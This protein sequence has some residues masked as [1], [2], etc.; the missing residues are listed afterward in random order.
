[1][2]TMAIPFSPLFD[3]PTS[4]ALPKVISH[5]PQLVF[6]GFMMDSIMVQRNEKSGGIEEREKGNKETSSDYMIDLDFTPKNHGMHIFVV[7][8]EFGNKDVFSVLK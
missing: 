8:D 7:T 2:V 5:N 3:T 6:S 4:Q 1:M